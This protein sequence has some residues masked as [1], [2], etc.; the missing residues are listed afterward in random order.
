M[1][2]VLNLKENTT[3]QYSKRVLELKDSPLRKLTPLID[4]QKRKGKSFI[5][6]NIGQPDLE[7]PACFFEAIRNYSNH[8]VPYAPSLGIASLI[9]AIQGYFQE[10]AISFQ[11]E[12]I[13]V[14]T[15]SSEAIFF[16]MNAICDPFDEVLIPEPFYVN[17]VSFMKQLDVV[18]KGIPTSVHDRYHLPSVDVI[19]S[20]ITSKTK[21]IMI[22]H[23]NNPTGTVYSIE[24]MMMLKD[25]AIKHHLYL[26]VDE[27]Y[28]GIVYDNITSRSFAS[29]CGLDDH[30]IIIDSVSKRYSSCGARIG[31]IVSRNH[32]LMKEIGKLAQA[33]LSAP[34]LDQVGAVS[35]YQLSSSFIEKCASTYE[36][37]R[38]VM[39]ESLLK[40]AGCHVSVPEGAFYC[41]VDTPFND[42]EAFARWCVEHF[43]QDHT[44]IVVAPA[45]DFY[46]NPT[47]GKH[48]IRLAFVHEP[49]II[50]KGMRLLEEAILQYSQ[51]LQ[52]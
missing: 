11:K 38:N 42:T 47:L 27:V 30:V 36:K 41:L 33:R 34:T 4:E 35:L 24:E 43:E 25:I 19:E 7:T 6:F 10:Q 29:L 16:V 1:L 28:T 2:S 22:T 31:A 8:N 23:P 52:K 37:R 48:Q 21:A 3:M 12:E 44:S 40:I 5:H 51:F 13:I 18:V 49:E 17:T 26:V 50:K 32:G 20:K 46:L 14:T 15:G 45:Q 9:E 39:V